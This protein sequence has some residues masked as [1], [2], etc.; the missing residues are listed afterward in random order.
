MVQTNDVMTESE[1]QD[2][3]ES[4]LSQ[5][6]GLL[7]KVIRAYAATLPDQDDLFQEIVLQVWR[8]IPKFRQ[9]SAVTTWLY[10]IALNTALKW[11]SKE[12][13]YQEG[14]APY[15]NME[16]LL[17]EK[18]KPMDSRLAWL[19]EEIAG[20]HEVD[21]SLM[22]LLLD[23]FNYKEM[24]EILGITESNVGVKVHRIK[25]QMIDR[26]KNQNYNYHGI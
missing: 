15:V 5:H 25:K 21:R 13:K 4:W 18:E 14:R 20:L 10:R 17:H 26:S 3:F 19:Y 6:K 8:S 9:E 16:Y 24:A 11:N 1:Q 12:Q 23:G 22:L 7:F 2:I